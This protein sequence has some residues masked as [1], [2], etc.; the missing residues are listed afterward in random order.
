MNTV[1]GGLDSFAR[2]VILKSMQKS[3]A[4][5]GAGGGH[6][7]MKSPQDAAGKKNRRESRHQSRDAVKNC[8]SS[9]PFVGTLIAFREILTQNSL[10]IFGKQFLSQAVGGAASASSNPGG[11]KKS[12]DIAIA[13]RQEEIAHAA[14]MISTSIIVAVIERYMMEFGDGNVDSAMNMF[15]RTINAYDEG[16][17]EFASH[18]HPEEGNVRG[19]LPNG[20]YLDEEEDI[21]RSASYNVAVKRHP[22]VVLNEERKLIGKKRKLFR[23]PGSNACYVAF[24]KDLQV[25]D[26]KL[27]A[28]SSSAAT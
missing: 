5:A 7:Q 1:A 20:Q 12:K 24:V 25:K 11:S 3:A 6:N 17:E 2:E 8:C 14:K 13:E 23:I 28:S 4:A 27:Q 10:N 21:A 16:H 15:F 9:K 26:G 18:L 19:V 22:L